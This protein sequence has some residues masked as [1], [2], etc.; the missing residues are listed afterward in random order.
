M[1]HRLAALAA[2]S[3][4]LTGCGLV[5]NADASPRAAARTTTREPAAAQQVGNAA[6]VKDDGDI[7]DP[8]TLLSEDD[9]STLTDRKVSQI[10][11]DGANA[12]DA[13]RYCQWQQDG[14]RLAVFLSR[15]TAAEF[16][17][18][19]AEAEPVED[20]GDQ[21]YA[22]S[23]HLY[24]LFGTVQIDVYAHGGTEK[25]NLSDEKDVAEAL[26]PKI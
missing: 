18:T 16:Q 19:V 1:K 8:C 2:L 4:A 20:L 6:S 22:H 17:V 12:G 24:V 9:I 3:L 7:P 15:T 5:N 23:G 13:T 21:A 14:G 26:L 25:Q 10:D 11:E